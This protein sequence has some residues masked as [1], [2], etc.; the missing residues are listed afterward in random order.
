MEDIIINY[1]ISIAPAVT[2]ILTA[3]GTMIVAYKKIKT[4]TQDANIQT[5]A[6]Q[7]DVSSVMK[8]NAELKRELRRTLR[9]VHRVRG[10]DDDTSK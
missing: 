2:A 5:K 1:I 3:I 6:L 10:D 7:R 4:A 8:E 9:M